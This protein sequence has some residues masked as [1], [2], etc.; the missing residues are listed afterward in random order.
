M[1]REDLGPPPRGAVPQRST[2]GTGVSWQETLAL[3][4]S[5]RQKVAH[6]R[7]QGADESGRVLDGKPEGG[8][9]RHVLPQAEHDDP[10]GRVPRHLHP[11]AVI[12]C[13]HEEVVVV[14]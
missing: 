5:R 14:T 12:A 3:G 11:A 6:D 10:L 8:A 9:A 7:R 13:V 2:P 1:K 4:P